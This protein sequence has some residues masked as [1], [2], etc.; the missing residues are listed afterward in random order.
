VG[1][2]A[3]EEVEREFDGSGYGALKQTVADLNSGKCDVAAAGMTITDARK[4]VLDFSEPYFDATQALAVRMR[5]PSD[6]DE[7]QHAAAVD[8]R[9]QPHRTHP[10][11]LTAERNGCGTPFSGTERGACPRN[12]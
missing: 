12:Q 10:P 2:T 7:R 6:E 4:Q 1:G 8:H 5:G 9:R 3:P 11:S